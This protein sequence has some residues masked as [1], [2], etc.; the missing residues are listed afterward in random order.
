MYRPGSITSQW[1][2]ILDMSGGLWRMAEGRGAVGTSAVQ[3]RGATSP[4][5]VAV[6]PLPGLG[7]TGKR[8]R[9]K[10]GRDWK[11]L[12]PHSL[13]PGVRAIPRVGKPGQSGPVRAIREQRA[14]AK[15]WR[16]CGG[17][18]STS[19]GDDKTTRDIH[20][21]AHEAAVLSHVP[22]TP[23]L[24]PITHPFITPSYLPC[25]QLSSI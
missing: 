14:E 13:G 12:S 25:F 9:V 5:L 20:I 8:E 17:R 24:T 22:C 11:W 15:I 4:L 19:K 7:T 3:G 16:R 6:V 1:P 10:E 2:L 18:V 21:H 23:T